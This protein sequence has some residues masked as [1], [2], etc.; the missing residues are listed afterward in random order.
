MS[1]PKKLKLFLICITNAGGEGKT[2][3]TMVLYALFQLIQEQVVLAD[4]DPGNRASKTMFP[5]A[6][7]IDVFDD[8]E[9]TEAAVLSEL[10][11]DQS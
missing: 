10:G 5:T 6:T 7:K 8:A 3:L 1:L 9:A 2:W 11:N 4:A